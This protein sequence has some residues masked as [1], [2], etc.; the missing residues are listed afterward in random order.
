MPILIHVSDHACCAMV[1]ENP[2]GMNTSSIRKDIHTA[3]SH[4]LRRPMTLF[5]EILGIFAWPRDI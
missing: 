4:E 5:E 3:W 2:M 1:F